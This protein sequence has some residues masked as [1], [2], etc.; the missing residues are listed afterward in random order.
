MLW[1]WIFVKVVI[2]F[3]STHVSS[4][5]KVI[6][7]GVRYRPVQ[8]LDSRVDGEGAWY[9]LSLSVYKRVGGKDVV[10]WA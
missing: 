6:A 2:R 7:E 1:L 5:S 9:K 8:R 3:C 4:S 10:N